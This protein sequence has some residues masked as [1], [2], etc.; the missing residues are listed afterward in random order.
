MDRDARALRRSR[1]ARTGTLAMPADLRLDAHLLVTDTDPDSRFSA[2]WLMP[3]G[4]F[5]G[6]RL[7]S[8]VTP[9]DWT[10]MRHGC[11]SFCLVNAVLAAQSLVLAHASSVNRE[12]SQ[13]GQTAAQIEQPPAETH[14]RKAS[15]P[16]LDIVL[17]AAAASWGAKTG[18][19]GTSSARFPAPGTIG[20][21]TET[22][23][24]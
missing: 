23:Q 14:R 9:N 22:G 8:F 1:T 19:R 6:E 10:T 24:A 15:R 4:D 16:E 17:Q 5:D 7:L 13:R 12:S 21:G 18:T 2:V 20:S 3:M 11:R